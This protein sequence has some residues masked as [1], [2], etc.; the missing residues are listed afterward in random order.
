MGS[1]ADLHTLCARNH[2]RTR[3]HQESLLHYIRQHPREA[4]VETDD[5]SLPLH[6][7]LKGNPTLEVVS[8]LIAAYPEAVNMAETVQGSYPLHIACRHGCS[9]DVV[10]YVI[11]R[12]PRLVHRRSSRFFIC[13]IQEWILLCRGHSLSGW[14]P[15]ELAQRLPEDHL[16]RKALIVL[17][18]QYEECKDSRCMS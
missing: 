12:N 15:K 8:C 18:E 14:T 7:L 4:S 6:L 9:P 3:K 11:Q 16:H 5:G 2:D 17:L 10:E 13:C 1:T